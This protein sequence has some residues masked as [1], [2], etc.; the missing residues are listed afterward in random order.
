MNDVPTLLMIY[1]PMFYCLSC[2]EG[3]IGQEDLHF[4]RASS[5][6]LTPVSIVIP[7]LCT[8]LNRMVQE[9]ALSNRYPGIDFN[10]S[11]ANS[12]SFRSM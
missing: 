12:P 1:W 10:I 7:Q 3:G 8:A 5:A 6:E 2:L 11:I 9:N 4:R